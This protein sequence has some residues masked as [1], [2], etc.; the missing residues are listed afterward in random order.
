[1]VGGAIECQVSI[2]TVLVLYEETS[3]AGMCTLAV[4]NDTT[5][6]S[7]SLTVKGRRKQAKSSNGPAERSA[8][9]GVL[10]LLG[11]LNLAAAWRLS[12]WFLSTARPFYSRRYRCY[13]KHALLWPRSPW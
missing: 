7:V 6:H 8:A 13:G 9:F 5:K 10:L 3:V 12:L 11:F 4:R 2:S 1:M